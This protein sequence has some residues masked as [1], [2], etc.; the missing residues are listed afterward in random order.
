MRNSAGMENVDAATR[1]ALLD[2]SLHLC[3]GNMDEAY[4][5][6]CRAALRDW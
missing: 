2:F 1:K 6:R 5:V 4:K 3:C